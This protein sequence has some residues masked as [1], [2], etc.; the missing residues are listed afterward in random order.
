MLKM[1]VAPIL[2]AD[3]SRLEKEDDDISSR[4]DSVLLRHPMNF[5]VSLNPGMQRQ[6]N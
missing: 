6:E 5:L 1:R 4:Y 3:S 2:F